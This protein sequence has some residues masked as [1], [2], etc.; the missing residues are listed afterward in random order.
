MQTILAVGGPEVIWL[1][2]VII[3]EIRY[4]LSNDYVAIF[5]APGKGFVP[6]AK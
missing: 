5:R 4:L 6:G 1:Q 2:L 3:R